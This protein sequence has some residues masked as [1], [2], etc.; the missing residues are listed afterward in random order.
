MST[1]WMMPQ[2]GAAL[3]GRLTTLRPI[4]QEDLQLLAQW[5]E[6]PDIVALMGRRYQCSVQEWFH[7]TLT[8][9]RCRA[10]AIED[11]AGNLVGE[12]ELEQINWRH[13]SAE[14]RICIGAKESWGQGLGYDALQTMLRQ[15]FMAWGL[16]SIYLR[17]Y[18]CNTRAIRLY[19]KLGFRL[20]G[21]L[22]GS[23]R[24]GDPSDVLLMTLTRQRWL[25][26]QLAM[27]AAAAQ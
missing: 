3:A 15:A 23:E 6:D 24:R 21:R 22:M 5:D 19:Q 27:P 14:L 13:G 2:P 25:R 4:R 7:H 20:E 9:R 11:L 8:D 26:R 1:D 18:V 10:L 17:V 16:Q 12:V